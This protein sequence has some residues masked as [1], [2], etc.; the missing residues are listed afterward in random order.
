MIIG[1]ILFVQ[2]MQAH[3]KMNIIVE[4]LWLICRIIYYSIESFIRLFVPLTAKNIEGEVAL[5][6]GSG[7]GIGR[8]IAVL[9]A[10]KGV[11]V[12]VCDINEVSSV[13]SS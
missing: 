6:T 11:R 10:Q 13:L 9:L 4:I 8:E 12:A 2:M 7:R 1:C 5:V 3:Q